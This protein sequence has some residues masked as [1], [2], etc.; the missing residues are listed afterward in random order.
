MESFAFSIAFVEEGDRVTVVAV[1]HQR[2][3]PRYWVKRL[4]SPT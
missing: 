3:R 1:A 4:R 2:R